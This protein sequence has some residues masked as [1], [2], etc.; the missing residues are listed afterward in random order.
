MIENKFFE[1]FKYGGV[2]SKCIDW[3]RYTHNLPEVKQRGIENRD[4]ASKEKEERYYKETL[5][6][7]IVKETEAFKREVLP[8]MGEMLDEIEDNIRGSKTDTERDFYLYSLFK[9]FGE[10]GCN[11]AGI[12]NPTAET[13]QMKQ[14]RRHERAKSVARNF[15]SLTVKQE[16]AGTVEKCT[17]FYVGVMMDFAD[18]LDALL[19]FVFEIDMMRLQ[20]ECGIYLK[21]H[22]ITGSVATYRGSEELTRELISALPA[23][24]GQIKPQREELHRKCEVLIS[25]GYLKRTDTGYKRTPKMTKALLAYFLEKYRVDCGLT[26]FPEMEFNEMF[27]EERLGK[28]RSQLADNK[29]GDGKPKGYEIIDSLFDGQL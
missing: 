23:E 4:E 25:G 22:R 21:F 12:Y 19:R 27:G 15:I 10:S 26:Y 3:M 2:V 28:A 13:A 29:H 7:E 14:S 1:A 6:N 9:P 5:P 18:R 24:I 16:Q 17:G 8:R 20:K 11:I